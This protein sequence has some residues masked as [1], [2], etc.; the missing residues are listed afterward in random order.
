MSRWFLFLILAVWVV[1]ML[2]VRQPARRRPPVSDFHPASGAADPS[3]TPQ[4]R[5]GAA[6][7]SGDIVD[8]EFEELSGP[9]KS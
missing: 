3:T 7:S 9:P 4:A 6:F 2:Q 1:R 5:D 8:A